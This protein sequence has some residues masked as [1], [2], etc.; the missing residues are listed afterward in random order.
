MEQTPRKL[1]SVITPC[2]N[3]ED[4]VLDCCR[5]VREVFERHLPAY[6]YEHIFCD[7][8]S[9]D[10]TVSIL[11][12]LAAENQRVKLLINAR[13]FGPLR[14]VFNARLSSSGDAVVVLLAADLQD[15]PELIVE[16][17]RQW[18]HGRTNSTINSG[19]S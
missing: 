11:K 1:I 4:N 15:P 5:A 17:V 7:N 14:S 10:Q 6:D 3:E 13:N 18:E 12:R 19:G 8:A 16:F 2:Y 9:A